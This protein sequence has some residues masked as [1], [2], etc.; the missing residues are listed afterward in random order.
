KNFDDHM[1]YFSR[2]FKIKIGGNPEPVI[3]YWNSFKRRM[4]ALYDHVRIRA[5]S[6]TLTQVGDKMVVSFYQ[7]FDSPNFNSFGWKNIDFVREDS[8][9]KIINEE[10]N[11][12]ATNVSSTG[13]PWVVHTSSYLDL[14]SATWEVNQLRQKGFNAYSSPVFVTS[15]KK[16]YRVFV[17]RFSDRNLAERVARSLRRMNF[18]PYALPMKYPCS[19]EVGVYKS[20]EEAAEKIRLLRGKGLSSYIFSTSSDDFDNPVFKVLLGAFPNQAEAKELIGK[21][22]LEGIDSRAVFP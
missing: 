11:Q 15:E 16:I 1:S 17:E 20:E 9:W 21:L 5:K 10:L 19:V 22:S 8:D 13:A 6:P 3:K 14:P 12:K 2:E 7:Q 4:F 18:G